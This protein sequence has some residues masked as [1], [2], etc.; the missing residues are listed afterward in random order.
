MT[1]PTLAQKR[2]NIILQSRKSKECVASPLTIFDL[3]YIKDLKDKNRKKFTYSKRLSWIRHLIWYS[4]YLKNKNNHFYILKYDGF[5]YGT[6]GIRWESDCWHI[7]SVIRDDSMVYEENLML[8]MCKELFLV[9][10]NFGNICCDVLKDNSVLNWYSKMGFELIQ[11]SEL[12]YFLV[13]KKSG[14]K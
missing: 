4:H 6:I 13:L 11:E 7:Y 8:E 10:G 9:Y 12:L 2:V 14:I 1:F 3:K 5:N